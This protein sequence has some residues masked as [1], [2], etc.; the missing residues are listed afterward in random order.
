LWD[1][2]TYQEVAT[3]KGKVTVAFSPDGR[4][5][6]S[7]A[8][9][10]MMNSIKLWSVETLQEIATL[11]GH[12]D[13]VTA[14]AFSPDG[15]LLV[16]ASKDSTIKLWKVQKTTDDFVLPQ[17][18]TPA[19]GLVRETTDAFTTDRDRCGLPQRVKSLN[20]PY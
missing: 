3:L 13:T 6:A 11:K 20:Q 17:K 19:F 5:L 9:G 1:V 18:A 8:A 2:R 4:L 10:K 12:R 7:A 14:V 16:S 15:Q